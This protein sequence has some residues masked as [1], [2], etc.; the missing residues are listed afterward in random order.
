ML[1]C[2]GIDMTEELHTHRHRHTH[3]SLTKQTSKTT[4]IF[5]LEPQEWDRKWINAA[6]PPPPAMVTSRNKTE[7]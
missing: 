5:Q 6:L 4:Q 1:I 2:Q 3:S 7:L